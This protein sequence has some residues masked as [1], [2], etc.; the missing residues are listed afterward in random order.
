MPSGFSQ[1]QDRVSLTSNFDEEFHLHSSCS[2][3]VVRISVTLLM[4]TEFNGEFL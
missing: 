3:V 1:C 4:L 2:V